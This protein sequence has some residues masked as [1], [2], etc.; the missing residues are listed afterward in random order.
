M[1]LTPLTNIH[2]FENAVYAISN[3]L[4]FG[5]YLDPWSFTTSCWVVGGASDAVQA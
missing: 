5:N 1:C 3:I 2:I 4:Y